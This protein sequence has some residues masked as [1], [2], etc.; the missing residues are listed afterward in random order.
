[1]FFSFDS[2]ALIRVVVN[3]AEVLSC[4]CFG[5]DILI[6][7]CVIIGPQKNGVLL[8]VERGP[9]HVQSVHLRV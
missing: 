2:V 7:V 1:M 3:L 5:K 9:P 6:L 4:F 8:G